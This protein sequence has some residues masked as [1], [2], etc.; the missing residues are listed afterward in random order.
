MKWFFTV[1][2]VTV[3]FFGVATASTAFAQTP[4]PAA[5]QGKTIYD[6]ASII[7]RDA[8]VRM[9]SLHQELYQKTGVGLIILTVPK[10]Q[11]ETIGQ[12]A[13]RAGHTWGAGKDDKGIVVALSVKDRKVF[14]ATGYGV[15]GFL[16]D[17]KVGRIRDQYGIPFF[18]KNQ[19]ARGLETLSGVLALTSA[20]EYG[21]TLNGVTP[22]RNRVRRPRRSRFSG[23]LFLLLLLFVFSRRGGLPI[24][25][26]GGGGG[27]GGGG[28]GGGG[29]GGGGFGGGGFGGGGAGGSF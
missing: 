6:E 3:A 20:Q 14:I 22:H 25:F 5:Q 27:F 17:G 7:S 28:F 21:V 12:L 2:F 18:K 13:V 16:P 19:F 1:V 8:A 26:F 15:E 10:L 11:D 29:F 4:L 9:E 24:I 23:L